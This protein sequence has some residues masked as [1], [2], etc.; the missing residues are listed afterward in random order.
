MLLTKQ[1]ECNLG[2]TRSI[3]YSDSKMYY[4][5][6]VQSLNNRVIAVIHNDSEWDNETIVT[7]LNGMPETVNM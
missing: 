1:S 5:I 3:V 7:M 2:D 4:T 6:V